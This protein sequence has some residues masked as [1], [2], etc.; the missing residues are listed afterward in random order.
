MLSFTMEFFVPRARLAIRLGLGAGA[1][2]E[3]G[4]RRANVR[5]RE[6]S[7]MPLGPGKKDEILIGQWHLAPDN[8]RTVSHLQGTLLTITGILINRSI[9]IAVNNNL[10]TPALSPLIFSTS[11]KES[12]DH[13]FDKVTTSGSPVLPPDLQTLPPEVSTSLPAAFSTG[14]GPQGRARRS[15][16][17]TPIRG[18][19]QPAD[20]ARNAQ[21]PQ[22]HSTC[23]KARSG[24]GSPDAPQS[25]PPRHAPPRCQPVVCCESAPPRSCTPG[26]RP[27]PWRGQ[28]APL[29]SCC[30]SS[31][32]PWRGC[33][34]CRCW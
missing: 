29:L 13:H 3:G 14:G 9:R 22:S 7:R 1:V 34:S 12:Y 4:W 15:G 18:R 28:G 11:A 26:V 6:T 31:T 8:N 2:V 33:C 20:R 32:R 16:G 21:Q 19:A 24:A 10:P 23:P 30:R 27:L 25:P 17:C 5:Q